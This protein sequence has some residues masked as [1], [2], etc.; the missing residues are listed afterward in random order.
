M[1]QIILQKLSMGLPAITPAFGFCLAEAAA[2][3][4]EQNG[5]QQGAKLIVQGDLEGSF[6][7]NWPNVTEQMYRCWNDNE[8][9]T[10]HGAYAIALS[11]IEKLTDF[12][13]VERSFKGTGID[14]WLGDK[15]D[16]FLRKKARL[17]VSGLR[18]GTQSEIKSRL[19]IKRHQTTPSNGILP[20]Y[21]VIVEF[22]QPTAQVIIK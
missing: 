20:A 16:M 6:P 8:V 4:L 12:T 5:H 7:L 11:L 18:K 9:A 10:E 22:S 15:N 21:I 13:I 14:Y 1:S 17:E 2:V 19:K 3:C